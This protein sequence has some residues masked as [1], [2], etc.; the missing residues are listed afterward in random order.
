MHNRNDIVKLGM[1]GVLVASLI[2]APVKP[3]QAATELTFSNWVNSVK[4]S[5]D[6]RIRHEIFHKKTAGQVD[7]QRQRFRLRI[8]SEWA[9]PHNLT[10]Y[11][12]LATG[13]GEQVSTNQSFD[14]LGS[15]KE[16]WIDQVYLK[17]KPCDG[18]ALSGGRL[19]NPIWRVYSSDIVWD[20][21]FNP[22]GFGQQFKVAIPASGRLFLNGL[23][24]VADE[25]SGT[26]N[27]QYM[28]GQQ[29]GLVFPLPA[30]SR[31]TVAG[32]Y[33]EWA[34]ERRGTFSQVAANEGNTRTGA[35]P[36][37]LTDE[38][39]VAEVTTEIASWIGKYPL[40][41]Q[42]TFIKNTRSLAT[43][44]PTK[45]DQGAQAGLIFGKASDPKSWEAAYFYKTV[46]TNA[47]VADVSDSDFGDGGTNRRGHILWFAY[48]P[49]SWLQAK[50]KCF[51]TETNNVAFAPG[52]DDINR[53]QFDLSVKF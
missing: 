28:F 8:G 23:Q 53:F 29:L 3:V 33:Y 44:T 32:A 48:N 18:L 49:E 10:G 6:L 36:G 26:V 13:T 1:A 5:G 20:D 41:F 16:I 45:E 21:D 35:A 12:K 4:I 7:R 22:E 2:A 43:A 14:N 15:Q 19:K 27:D 30:D 42:G 39:G 17:W 40:A 46:E 31:I 51:F 25:D 47:T 50:V 11:L 9:L 24:M 38:F 52:T 34:H 37:T